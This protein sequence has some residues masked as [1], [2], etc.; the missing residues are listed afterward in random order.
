VVGG[1]YPVFRGF[2]SRANPALVTLCKLQSQ[3]MQLKIE[4]LVY[5]GD[6]LARLPADESGPGKTVFVPFSIDGER[7]DADIIEQKR[8]FARAIP[9]RI[10]DLSPDRV[11][12]RCPYFSQCGGCHYQ[13]VR[14]TRQIEAKSAILLETLKR[15]AKI[16]LP[17]KLEI[18]RSPEWNYRNRTR[19]KVQTAPEFALGYY[20][21]RSHELLPIEQCPISSPLI[22][23]AI[24]E[25][26]AAGRAGN[27]PTNIREIELF[28]DHADSQ[29]LLELYCPPGAAR[30]SS[31]QTAEK[32]V[33]IFPQITGVS[34]FEQ[35]HANHIAEPIRVA[36]FGETALVYETKLARYRVS[37]GAFFQVNRFLI[38][39]LVGIVTDG[40][41]GKLALDLYAGVGL[42]S[43]VLAKSFAQVIAVEASQTSHA[44]LRHNAPQEVKAVL[45]TTEQYLGQV[46]GI[47]PDLVVV[48]PP[49]GGLG[50]NVVRGL[51]K[52]DAPKITYVSCDPSTLAR[53]LRMLIG[54][55]YRVMGAHLIDLFPQTY[56]IESVFHLAR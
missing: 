43:S 25:I 56:H 50:E 19:L 54:L 28:A 36:A 38:D 18:H 26:W 51:A 40:A 15:T 48:D 52:L 34:L 12:P 55:G 6:G 2:V 21:F 8:G 17:C 9:K 27:I 13:H 22:N 30:A 41:S 44:D 16:E 31:Q 42:F 7:I 1:S 20:K 35:P 10:L 37:A 33:H 46:S 29:L 53:D 5:G 47:R 32:V 11:E 39:E 4:K 23:R 14:Y 24:T 49:R 3:S 45:A